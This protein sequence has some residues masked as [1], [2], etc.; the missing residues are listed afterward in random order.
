[1]DP[2]SFKWI[3]ICFHF[4]IFLG[5]C[6]LQSY[7]WHLS[8]LG[9]NLGS[10]S[11]F[12]IAII[13]TPFLLSIIEISNTSLSNWKIK[14]SFHYWYLLNLTIPRVVLAT[15]ANFLRFP[16]LRFPASRVRKAG[17]SNQN[18]ISLTKESLSYSIEMFNR[19]IWPP[20]WM[21]AIFLQ[22]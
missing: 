22:M 4:H 2:L 6:L 3:D 9:L 5:K 14:P 21:F 12:E 1:M 20:L 13:Y 8:H 15:K 18:A 7:L 19:R 11:S 16:R 17:T 10:S